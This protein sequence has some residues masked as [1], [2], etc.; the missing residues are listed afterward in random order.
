MSG[1]GHSPRHCRTLAY[2]VNGAGF[3]LIELRKA[4]CRPKVTI[5]CDSSAAWLGGES[6]ERGWN[7][8]FAEASEVLEN[9]ATP[10]GGISHLNRQTIADFLVPARI[11]FT[12]KR[13]PRF[14]QCSSLF[15]TF[16]VLRAKFVPQDASRIRLVIPG[17]T[18][19]PQQKFLR[20]LRDV[21]EFITHR[22]EVLFHGAVALLR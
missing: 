21:I 5:F 15:Y 14:L 2:S 4:G 20:T 12:L 11:D 1:S 18:M 6:G 8:L 7:W 22:R 3:H 10:F 9:L 16:V 19:K 13:L 17:A